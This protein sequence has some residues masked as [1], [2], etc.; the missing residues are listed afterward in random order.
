M[1]RKEELIKIKKGE[2]KK[3]WGENDIKEKEGRIKR[4]QKN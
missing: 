2:K 1:E 3:E 4:K